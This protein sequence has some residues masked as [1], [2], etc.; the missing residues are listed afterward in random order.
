MNPRSLQSGRWIYFTLYNQCLLLVLS[1]TFDRYEVS[2]KYI[3]GQGCHDRMAV[4][5]TTTCA[6]SAYHH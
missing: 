2:L 4:G 1:V 6:I 3:C 5:F